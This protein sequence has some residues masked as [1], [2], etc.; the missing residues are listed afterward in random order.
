MALICVGVVLG[1]AFV[2]AVIKIVDVR[3]KALN[4]EDEKDS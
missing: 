3:A 1:V 4:L 2:F